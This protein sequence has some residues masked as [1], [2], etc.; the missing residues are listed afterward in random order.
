MWKN[1]WSFI[2]LVTNASH[3]INRLEKDVERLEKENREANREIQ[4][5]WLQLGRLAERENFRDEMLRREFDLERTKA[6]GERY[7]AETEQARAETARLRTE[8]ERR[9]LPAS[10]IETKDDSS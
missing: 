9:S 5:L 10:S 4:S 1:I 2:E 6:E 3:R 7:K 8:L